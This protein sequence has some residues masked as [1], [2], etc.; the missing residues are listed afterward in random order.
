MTTLAHYYQR[1]LTTQFHDYGSN[2]YERRR[3][4]KARLESTRDA[5][6]TPEK[7]EIFLAFQTSACSR[8]PGSKA[9]MAVAWPKAEDFGIMLADL[10][11]TCRACDGV[12]DFRG[13]PCKECRG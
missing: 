3:L 9:E 6:D 2:T 7:V 12:G 11:A 5:A 8:Y 4:I 13:T 10:E 1:V